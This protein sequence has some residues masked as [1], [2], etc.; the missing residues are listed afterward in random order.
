[1]FLVRRHDKYRLMSFKSN[2]W[3]QFREEP[4]DK[5]P[6]VFKQSIFL[7]SGTVIFSPTENEETGDKFSKDDRQTPD[8]IRKYSRRFN[9]DKVQHVELISKKLAGIEQYMLIM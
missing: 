8:F 7:F 6:D 1:M 5:D 4:S 2:P 3:L 9:N